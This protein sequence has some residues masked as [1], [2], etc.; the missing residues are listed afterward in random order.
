MS[1]GRRTREYG[2]VET[3][4]I[5]ASARAAADALGLTES[6]VHK[7]AR[8]WRP[9]HGLHIYRVGALGSGSAPPDGLLGAP[10]GAPYSAP[11]GTPVVCVE[12]G[13]VFQTAR[14]AAEAVGRSPDSIM[15]ACRGGGSCA[16]LHW[17]REGFP[18]PARPDGR[19]RPVVCEDAGRRFESMSAAA[20][21]CGGT[22]GGLSRA[23]AGKG[24]YRGHRFE[25][26]DPGKRG[27]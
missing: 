27:A 7:A 3:G 24:D 15:R 5:Y 2:C 13:G 21:W 6:M 4:E 19:A 14:D 12:T 23:M 1:T 26:T 17:R 18:V 9:A 10:S 22:P 16:G 20:R 25:A 8:W 11:R